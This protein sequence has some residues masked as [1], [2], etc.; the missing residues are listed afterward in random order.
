MIVVYIFCKRHHFSFLDGCITFPCICE[1]HFLSLFTCWWA[2][3]L[4]PVPGCCECYSCKGGCDIHVSV[5]SSVTGSCSSSF[6]CLRTL[7]ADFHSGCTI[8]YSHQPSYKDCSFLH[9]LSIHRH[10]FSWCELF[11]L[12]NGHM[13]KD[14]KSIYNH[15][16]ELSHSWGY[17]PP[18]VN[19]L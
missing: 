2:S 10:L 15:I 11:W 18:G 13:T 1:A 7:H 16:T 8:L 4:V 3:K 5:K 19:M 14:P 9:L 17:S 12:G 6:C